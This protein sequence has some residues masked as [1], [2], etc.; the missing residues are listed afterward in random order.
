MATVIYQITGTM[1][2]ELLSVLVCPCDHQPLHYSDGRWLICDGGHK[3]PVIEGVPVLL[4]DDVTATLGVEPMSI[5]R[6]RGTISGDPRAPELYLE[7][8]G[9]SE[10]EKDGIARLWQEKKLEIDPVVQYLV[11]ATCGIAYKGAIGR[12]T[13]YPIPEIPLPASNGETLIDIGCNWGRWS[14][15]AARKG[16]RVIGVDP[17]LGAVIAAARVARQLGEDVN[18]VCAD[19]RFLPFGSGGID[20][21]FSYSVLQHFSTEDC[22]KSL[23]EISRVLKKGGSSL[24][25]MANLLGVRSM[26]HLFRRC[27]REPRGFEVRYYTPWQMARS[28]QSIVGETALFADCYFG[29]GLQASDLRFMQGMLRLAT[30]ISTVL[31]KLSKRVR[32]LVLLADSLYLRSI[33]R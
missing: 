3:Y 19:A 17:Q 7:S 13:E 27:F 33:K 9:L 15:A 31:S 16:Y 2:E 28:F 29:L 22:R 26:Y 25:Q 4:M 23:G 32:P 12:L 24:I 8:L 5:G 10:L 20:I 18:F 21:A 14:F 30:R 11:G 1:K 6:A